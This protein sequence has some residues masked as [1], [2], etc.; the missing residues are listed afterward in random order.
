MARKT[1]IKVAGS[2]LVTSSV[3]APLSS[4][5]ISK[6]PLVQRLSSISGDS[7]TSISHASGLLDVS[8]LANSSLS[9][10]ISNNGLQQM[11][12][13]NYLASGSINLL[14]I[15]NSYVIFELPPE[16]GAIMQQE[17]TNFKSRLS[18]EYDVPIL[19]ALGLGIARSTGTVN[20]AKIHL[21]PELNQVYID[22][23]SLL[24]VVL[25]GSSDYKFELNITL[26][27]IPPSESGQYIFR[28]EVTK[29]IVDLDVMSTEP[30]IAILSVPMPEP[31]PERTPT[32]TPTLE[33]TPT[34]SADTHSNT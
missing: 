15:S 34:T 28:A 26:D 20:A 9:A 13:I 1:A 27:Y 7:F 23:Y 17:G 5:P 10:N 22:I 24:S 30:A 25:L 16:L 11:I 29:Q 32:P 14:L 33:P 31:T 6:Y 12:S 4:L 3:I 18:A 21:N 19:G 2:L 8:L